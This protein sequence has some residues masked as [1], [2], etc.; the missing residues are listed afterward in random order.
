VEGEDGDE[1]E[2]EEEE[3]SEDAGGVSTDAAEG[4]P[5]GV[6]VVSF[7]CSRVAKAL[8]WTVAATVTLTFSFALDARRAGFF[9]DFCER[10]EG[11]YL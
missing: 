7:D 3:N 2:E 6:G 11:A 10:D 8:S 1:E 9:C 5:A 4:V